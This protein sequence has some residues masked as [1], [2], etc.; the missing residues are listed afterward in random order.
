MANVTDYPLYEHWYKTLN[1]ILDRCDRMPKNTRFTV[2]N[3]IVQ[4]SVEI[5]EWIIEAIYSKDRIELLKAMNK[6]LEKLR[7]YFRIC[8]DRQYLNVKQYEFI[9][10]E[11]NKAGAMCGGW[12]K[13]KEVKDA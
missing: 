13:N 9:S 1:W 7:L 10:R 12:M 3:R 5:A 11:I 2:N 8:K 4:L 6:N